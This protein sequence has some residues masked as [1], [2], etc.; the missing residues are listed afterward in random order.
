MIHRLAHL[1]KYADKLFDI[2]PRLK[3]VRDRRVDPLIPSSAVN[4]TLLLG[5]ILRLP[6]LLDIANKTLRAGWQRLIGYGPISH[7]TLGYALARGHLEDWREMLVG[8]NRQLKANKRFEEAK[9]GGYLV[10]AVDANEQFKSRSRCCA[11]CCQRQIKVRNPLGV[12]CEVTEYYHRQVYAQLSGPTFSVILDVEP[13]RPGEEEAAAALR[14]L[15][16]MR[17]LY[18]VRFI[19]GVT[20]DAWYAK[21]PFLRA[22]EK[23]GWGVVCVLKDQRYEIYQEATALQAQQPVERWKHGGRAIEVREVKDLPFTVA[24]LGLVRVV[25]ADETW[26]ETT[27]V[28][29]E[30][31]QEDKSSHWRWLVTGKFAPTSKKAIW[32]MGHRRWGIENHTFNELTQ[33]YQLEHCPRHEAAAITVWLLIRVLGFMLFELFATLYCKTVR[34]GNQTMKDLRDELFMDLGNWQELAPLWSG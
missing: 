11:A 24:E 28:G 3:A 27:V 30:R 8:V 32:E 4:A 17:R 33:H 2:L 15:G 5:A 23:L 21:G 31:Q 29:G 25:L 20:V 14:L 22:V 26:V 10:A 19:D 16:R 18:G 1:W 13:I 12:E 9:I 34:Q 6:S 7:D